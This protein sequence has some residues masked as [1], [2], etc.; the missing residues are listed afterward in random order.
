[1]CLRNRFSGFLVVCLACF[2]ASPTASDTI[3]H[4]VDYLSRAWTMD[5]GLP[6]NVVLCVAQ[7]RDGFVWVGTEAG[8]A[9]LDGVRITILTQEDLPLDTNQ[10]RG[11]ASSPD[12][13][14]IVGTARGRVLRGRSGRWEV[15]G[16]TP[17]TGFG[18]PMPLLARSDGSVWVGTE[19][20]GIAVFGHGRARYIDADTGMPSPRING[21]AATR[22][23]VWAAT[24]AGLV[25]IRGERVVR[26]IGETE[27]LRN[28][29]VLCVAA[30]GGGELWAGSRNGDLYRIRGGK[31]F[32]IVRLP[33]A[34]RDLLLMGPDYVW[35]ATD[36]AEILSVRADLASAADGYR[37][38]TVAIPSTIVG[39]L[40]RDREGGIWAATSGRGVL[41]LWRRSVRTIGP[42]E[43]LSG[44]VALAVYEDRSGTL[45]VGT[46]G[47]GLNAIEAGSITRYG[48]TDGLPSELILA[49]GE[50]ERGNLLVGTSNGLCVRSGRRFV[51]FS[52]GGV[53]IPYAVST[54]LRTRSGELWVGTHRRGL[55]HIHGQAV[56]RFGSAE[57]L[58]EGPVTAIYETRDGTVL[59]GMPGGGLG[60]IRGDRVERHPAWPALRR[61]FVLAVHEDRSGALWLATLEHG[62]WRVRGRL[63]ASIRRRHGLPSETIYSI[64]ERGGRLWLSSNRGIFAAPLKELE[65]VAVGKRDRISCQVFGKADGMASS[66]CNG[67][68]WPPACARR[69]GTLWY[70]TVQGVCSVD[71]REAA[72]NHVRPV[73]IIESLAADGK[74]IAAEPPLVL[75]AGTRRL[76][77]AFTAP[78]FANPDDLVFEVRLDGMDTEWMELYRQRSISY[79]NLRPGV[80]TLRVAARLPGDPVTGPEATISVRVRPFLYQTPFFWAAVGPLMVA[81]VAAAFHGRQRRI[82]ELERRVRARTAALDEANREMEAFIYSV[83]HDLRNPLRAIAAYANL[84]EEEHA[85]GLGEDGRAMAAN[86]RAASERLG[87]LIERLLAISRAGRVPMQEITV[88]MEALARNALDEALSGRSEP[89]EAVIGT[90]PA[91]RGDPVLL[92]QVWA[93]LL[94]NAFKFTSKCESPRIEVDARDERDEI[95]YRVRDNGAGFDMQYANKLFGVFQRLHPQEE[96]AGT[97]AG[98]AIVKRIVE[99]HGGRVW[100]EGEPGKGACFYFALPITRRADRKP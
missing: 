42:S 59:V 70:P 35:V 94:G 13:G 36:G 57:G 73:A 40:V 76:E 21:L 18:P 46:A 5:D 50:D 58:P 69:D 55:Y 15:L 39:M 84:L 6:G 100:A 26:R 24:D 87:V 66:E 30:G 92:G 95:V 3:G 1:M 27:G 32:L 4:T 29:A 79:T 8:L 41:R 78:L 37:P 91:V 16:S 65:E 90:L 28:Q 14:L 85:E 67:G 98:L 47:A 61:V 33:A 12:G 62:V 63:A 72:T 19:Q 81:L 51:P 88:D 53:G 48:A 34:P 96:F 38:D 93:N 80:Y 43:G 89:V 60:V 54:I 74:A 82:A 25:E 49:L 86:I 22:D 31:A 97:G 77:A 45:W 20:R 64:L 83:A 11:L 99:R 52:R 75:K 9:R 23:G 17:R 10:I 68:V 2:T 44:P 7:T 56:R 71:P